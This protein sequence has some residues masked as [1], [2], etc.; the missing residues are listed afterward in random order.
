MRY[1]LNDKKQ[2]CKLLNGEVTEFQ[3]QSINPKAYKYIFGKVYLGLGVLCRENGQL[4]GREGSYQHFWKY[5]G[6]T[7]IFGLEDVL[8]QILC[9]K[10]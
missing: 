7:D 4:I 6:K 5:D 9:Y 1:G 3:F 10:I 2:Y 8:E